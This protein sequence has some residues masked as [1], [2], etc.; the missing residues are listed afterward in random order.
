MRDKTG[1][2][3]MLPNNTGI[4]S[5]AGIRKIAKLTT[6]DCLS[7]NAGSP[8]AQAVEPRSGTGH[9]IGETIGG[10]SGWERVG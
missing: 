9:R 6:S 7:S 3:L 1:K 4:E 2:L 8:D 10:R 5:T